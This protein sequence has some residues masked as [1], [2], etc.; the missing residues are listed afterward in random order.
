MSKS[1]FQTAIFVFCLALVLTFAEPAAAQKRRNTAPKKTVAENVS[2]EER[3]ATLENLQGAKAFQLLAELQLGLAEAYVENKVKGELR[4]NVALTKLSIERLRQPASLLTLY[5]HARAHSIWIDYYLFRQIFG[6]D[7]ATD[8]IIRE[9]VEIIRRDVGKG[10]EINQNSP[11]LIAV[12]GSLRETECRINVYSSEKDCHELPLADL[13]RA[14]ALKPDEIDFYS[15]RAE[16]FERRKR[17]IEA[18][19]DNQS[20]KSLGDAMRLKL[21][22]DKQATA[23]RPFH[24]ERAGAETLYFMQIA[25]LLLDQNV[26]A[27]LRN[28][29]ATLKSFRDTLMEYFTLADMSYIKAN[30]PNATADRLEQRGMLRLHL[31]IFAY[32]LGVE[33]PAEFARKN[34]EEAVGFYSEAMRRDAKFAAAYKN[35]ARAYRKLG[36]PEMAEADE[37]QFN[38]LNGK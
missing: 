22:I 30:S 27:Q 18:A 16:F 4:A 8:K 36:K 10:L 31:G 5:A 9:Y 6:T 15:L 1:L 19:A 28:D 35:R 13:S 3:A 34:Y 25:S 23:R 11:F 20:A 14:I 2:D 21:D 32:D 7:A 29:A 38:L 26:K 12:R 17:P 37:K 33:Q 24:A